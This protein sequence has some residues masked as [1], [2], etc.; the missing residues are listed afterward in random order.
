[1]NA[2]LQVHGGVPRYGTQRPHAFLGQRI[3]HEKIDP[4][5]TRTKNIDV[6]HV[7]SPNRSHAD[8]QNK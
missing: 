8:K 4:G 2:L 3:C 6:E 7:R 5:L 1:M